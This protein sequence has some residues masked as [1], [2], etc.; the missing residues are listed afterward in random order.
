M[1]GPPQAAKAKFDT[2]MSSFQSS[3]ASSGVSFTD[4]AA[5]ADALCAHLDKSVADAEGLQLNAVVDMGPYTG[6]GGGGK[7]PM[8]LL[9]VMAGG[10][11]AE[12][13]GLRHMLALGAD[14]NVRF[15]F[16]S[17]YNLCPRL[18]SLT[19]LTYLV[20]QF[21]LG[22]MAEMMKLDAAAGARALLDAGA[23]ANAAAVMTHRVSVN[24]E[25]QVTPHDGPAFRQTAVMLLASQCRAPDGSD[26]PVT[27]PCAAAMLKALVEKGADLGARAADDK[28]VRE[29]AMSAEAAAILA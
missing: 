26:R 20:M 5:M 23:D 29:L 7:T 9:L 1:L 3:V 19:P 22:G 21:V 24:S 2:F 10:L 25:P 27:G 28:T 4:T 18:Y 15:D 11:Y 6:Y 17:N 12:A 8:Y 14:P 16:Y 13:K